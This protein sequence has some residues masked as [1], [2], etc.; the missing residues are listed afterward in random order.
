[1]QTAH[2][3]DIFKEYLKKDATQYA[4]L[5]NGTWGSGK[6]FFWKSTLQ[7][8]VKE[9][10]LKPLYISLNGLK[11]IEQLQQQLMIKLIP[12]FGKPENKAL[13]NIA[14]LTGNVGN[15]VSKFFK[16]DLSNILSG[17]TLDGLKF[18][19][20]VI[21]FDDLERCQIPIKE[22]FGFINDFVEHKNLKC[23][24]LADAIKIDENAEYLK[25]KEKVIGRELNYEP[26]L[27]KVLPDL[28]EKYKVENTFHTFLTENN[29]YIYGIFFEYE[30][31]NL[32]I[33]SFFLDSLFKIYVNL[34]NVASEFQKEVILFTALISIEFKR[35]QLKSNDSNDYNGL[36]NT[37][38][39]WYQNSGKS[40]P[41]NSFF[42][43]EKKEPKV[44]PTYSEKFYLKYVE[45]RIN[46]FQFYGSIY[47]FILSG[48]LDVKNLK[49]ELEKRKPE[50][51][52]EEVLQ[53]MKLVTYDF[54]S[55]DGDEFEKLVANVLQNAEKGLYSIYDYDRLS[56]FYHFFSQ[57]SLVEKTPNEIDD[58][59][60]KGLDLASKRKEIDNRIFQNLAHFGV[61]MPEMQ[62]IRDKIIDVHKTLTE[63]TEAS[64][65]NILIELLEKEKIEELNQLFESKKYSK[66]F[67]KYIDGEQLFSVITSVSNATLVHFTKTMRE[68]YKSSSLKYMFPDDFDCLNDLKKS[69]DSLILKDGELSKLRI[70]NWRELLEILDRACKLLE[71]ED[72]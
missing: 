14:R 16:V 68:R 38:F 15:T 30:E 22:L 31:Y 28:C 64:E 7:S 29:D 51:H 19:D 56:N 54:R 6:T 13:K 23:L 53:F 44:E 36:E 24:I 43:E 66:D 57:S 1:M 10:E 32:R 45:S 59:L 71:P 21:C 50:E 39:F 4:L 20:K 70:F 11:T 3:E 37:S 60:F 9:Q 25:I 26:E 5:I 2:I 42:P 18:N 33:I 65:S 46:E 72:E 63:E 58:I 34:K 35:G 49:D 12:F 69:I 27:A 8:I 17:V 61:S 47:T 55:I 67:L 62:P 41:L 48:Y 40:V 52:P